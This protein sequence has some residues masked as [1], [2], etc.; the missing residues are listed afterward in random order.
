[1]IVELKSCETLIEAHK[2]QLL[3][4][5]KATGIEV[6]LIL[7]FGPKP[8]ISRRIYEISRQTGPR[9]KNA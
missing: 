2:A 8:Q 7:N 6:G 3:N 9:L 4:Y 1:V 5:L